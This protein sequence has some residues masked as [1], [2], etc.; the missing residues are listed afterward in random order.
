MAPE[1]MWPT[2]DMPKELRSAM[3]AEGI[4]IPAEIGGPP[5]LHQKVNGGPPR[6]IDTAGLE[7]ERQAALR[8]GILVPEGGADGA[9]IHVPL[10]NDEAIIDEGDALIAR[11]RRQNNKPTPPPAPPMSIITPDVNSMVYDMPL[12]PG[13][14]AVLQLSGDIGPEDVTLLVRYLKLTAETLKSNAVPEKHS[15]PEHRP[16]GR[17]ETLRAQRHATGGRNRKP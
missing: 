13:R 16:H 9:S 7:A 17:A 2:G 14:R 11:L 1:S 15:M 5:E 10:R 3:R 6:Q 4:D 8:D 12:R